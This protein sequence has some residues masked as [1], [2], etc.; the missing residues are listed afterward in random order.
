MLRTQSLA[1]WLRVI[2]ALYPSVVKQIPEGTYRI[3]C[4]TR[5]YPK[6]CNHMES[7]TRVNT[8]KKETDF[9]YYWNPTLDIFSIKF[10]DNNNSPK[11]YVFSLRRLHQSLLVGESRE[12]S[13]N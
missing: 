2:G 6:Y 9:E 11:N 4:G 12:Q 7:R 10:I 8:G 3:M 1:I 13:K 5:V